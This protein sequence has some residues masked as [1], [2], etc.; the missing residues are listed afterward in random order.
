MNDELEWIEGPMLFK[1]T[2]DRNFRYTHVGVLEF[3]ANLD[4]I[5]VPKWI[6][7][8]LLI[9]E[10]DKVTIESILLPPAT[11]LKFQPQSVE[12]LD[13]KEPKVVLQQQLQKYACITRGDLIAIKH[14]DKFYELW[15]LDVK[16]EAA[17][18]I[19]DC[20]LKV[21]RF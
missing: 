21:S 1:L 5:H 10:G 2:C 15:V 11:Y 20:E 18:T 13:I 14:D 19:I 8:N 4:R 17:V 12:F 16:P 6:M 7:K 9:K 3:T